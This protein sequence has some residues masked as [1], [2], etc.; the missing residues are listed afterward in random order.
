[1]SNFA[2]ICFV[3]K[4]KISQKKKCEISR[5]NE[6]FEIFSAK[7]INAKKRKSLHFFYE[8]NS[9]NAKLS[10][11]F[12]RND[13][14]I[15]LIRPTSMVLKL[16]T[17][18]KII[19]NIILRPEKCLHKLNF[20]SNY[21]L[22]HGSVLFFRHICTFGELDRKNAKETN[23]LLFINLTAVIQRLQA[24]KLKEFCQ[25]YLSKT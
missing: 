9:K 11:T 17:F 12:L 1:M 25:I 16:K 2:F 6:N 5:K 10:A 13:F 18:K 20:Y 3:K 15:S 24:L 4:C 7:Q 23:N 21:I 19:K 22:T 14:P 8:R